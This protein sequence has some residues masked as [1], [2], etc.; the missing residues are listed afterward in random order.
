[1]LGL[2]DYPSGL[3][4]DS[5]A[6][7]PVRFSIPSSETDPSSPISSPSGV[8]KPPFDKPDVSTQRH[9]ARPEPIYD[10]GSPGPLFG[11]YEQMPW[12]EETLLDWQVSVGPVLNSAANM[13]ASGYPS[14]PAVFPLSSSYAPSEAAN[15]Q[16]AAEPESDSEPC[17][18]GLFEEDIA[19]ILR[20]AELQTPTSRPASVC[21]AADYNGDAGRQAEHSHDS[22]ENIG[23]WAGSAPAPPLCDDYALVRTRNYGMVV[24][25][26]GV[27]DYADGPLASM[28]DGMHFK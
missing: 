23:P 5:S 13:Q 3:A 7:D 10:L 6:S 21:S 20:D 8:V 25:N 14:S 22:C 17:S 27:D 18:M 26:S 16:L 24:Y 11:R 2:L 15:L 28:M 19:S 4:E 1:M 12:L 9:E